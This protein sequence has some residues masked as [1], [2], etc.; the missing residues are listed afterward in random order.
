MLHLGRALRQAADDAGLKREEIDGIM[1][2]TGP[3]E[4]SMDKL[5]EFLG[6]PNVSW[7]FQSWFH[8]RLQ[9]TCLALAALAVGRPSDEHRLLL[10]WTAARRAS[11]SVQWSWC[12]GQSRVAS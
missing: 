6:L 2:N 1:V 3:E 5:P 8:G 7:A 11:R 10:D 9:P 12:V 4:A